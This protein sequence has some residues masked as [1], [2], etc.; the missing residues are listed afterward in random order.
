[1]LVVFLSQSMQFALPTQ[2]SKQATYHSLLRVSQVTSTC[3]TVEQVTLWIGLAIC[4]N[5]II[6]T[7][8]ESFES[9]HQL[10]LWLCSGHLRE[11]GPA[12]W[13]ERSTCR[14]P[15]GWPNRVKYPCSHS[16][17]ISEEYY[18]MGIVIHWTGGTYFICR[19]R[20]HGRA[21]YSTHHHQLVP[22]MLTWATA[23]K[24]PCVSASAELQHVFQHL[25]F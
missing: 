4:G 22:K 20:R 15:S 8:L 6:H 1:M 23:K 14:L 24:I 11:A 16:K 9:V 7:Q 10:Y 5:L 3:L 19:T 2:G 12:H 25:P 17:K 21:Q 13:L 18:N